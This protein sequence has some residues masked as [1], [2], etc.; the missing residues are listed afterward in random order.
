MIVIGAGFIGAEAA[1]AAASR[2]TDVIMINNNPV[3]FTAQLGHDMGA[4]VAS[5][6]T[7]NGVNLVSGTAID[8]FETAHGRVTGLRLADGRRLPANVVVVG[9]GAEPNVEWLEDSAVEPCDGALCDA[10]GRTNVRASSPSEIVQHGLSQR[11]NSPATLRG[12][13]GWKLKL[14]TRSNTAS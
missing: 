9:I 8:E 11:S 2:G 10:M 7:L 13:T 1:S 14:A 12:T 4:T 3:P 6:H 5:L